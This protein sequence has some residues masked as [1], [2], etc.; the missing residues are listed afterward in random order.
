M[1]LIGCL[2]IFSLRILNS[3]ICDLNCLRNNDYYQWKK[4]L[5]LEGITFKFLDKLDR[6][7][8]PSIGM[9]LIL[10]LLWF[11]FRMSE[12]FTE[13]GVDVYNYFYTHKSVNLSIAC[14]RNKNLLQK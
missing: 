7:V 2:L 5:F 1:D 8:N 3:G 9:L 10:K 4:K 12:I 14:N 6:H 11:D 13:Q